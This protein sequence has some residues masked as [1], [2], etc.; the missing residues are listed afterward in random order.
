MRKDGDRFVL[1]EGAGIGRVRE[2][3][4]NAQQVMKAYAWSRAMGAE[5]IRVEQAAE[6][7]PALEQAK[8]LNAEGRTVLIAVKTRAEDSRAPDRFA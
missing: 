6:M 1:D 7:A 8:R 5:G 2:Y 4:G 3:L